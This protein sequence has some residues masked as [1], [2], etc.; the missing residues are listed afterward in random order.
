[1]CELQCC[2]WQRAIIY[3]ILQSQGS[4][5][6]EDLTKAESSSQHQSHDKGYKLLLSN[7]QTFIS[8]LKSFV[9]E[10][11]VNTIKETDLVRVEKSY[12]SQDFSKREADIVYQ[13]RTESDDIIF[14]CL[15]EL[16]SEVDYLMPFRLLIYMTEIWRDSFKNSDPSPCFI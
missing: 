4:D 3:G 15:L 2:I 5:A 8:L 12:I 9:H 6:V 10:D 16:Q 1:M 14:Y 13:L 11:W 7:K